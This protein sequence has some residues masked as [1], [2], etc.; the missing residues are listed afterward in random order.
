MV[1]VCLNGVRGAGDGSAVPL[2]PEAMAEAAERA[3]AAGARE[4]QLHPKSPCG[5]DTLSPR[6]VTA[7]LEAVRSRVAVPVG[8]AAAAEVDPGRRVERVRSWTV[9][10]DHVSVNWAEPGAEELAT[11]LIERGVGIEAGIS[12]GTG[13]ARRFLASPWG[14]RVLRVRAEVTEH[15]PDAAETSAYRLLA[16]LG[17]AHGRPVL[18]HGVAGGAWPV[19]WLARRLGLGVRVGLED[20]L[21]LPDGRPAT[22][23]AQ[24]VRAA[25][26]EPPSGP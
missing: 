4:V 9:L 7:T 3:V 12:S 17:A 25:S 20:T 2:S 1:Q 15:D 23:N 21:L 13:A 22:S 6:A 26:A 8:V 24:L 11:A 10:P 5:H 18:L 19:V 16:D 14:P